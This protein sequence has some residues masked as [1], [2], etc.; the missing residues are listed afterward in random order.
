MASPSNATTDSDKVVN[1]LASDGTYKSGKFKSTWI[2][3]V[4]YL[5]GIL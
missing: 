4:N 3:F 5:L 1:I 2:K